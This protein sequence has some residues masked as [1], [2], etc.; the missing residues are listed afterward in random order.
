MFFF[1]QIF[2]T[3]LPYDYNVV[4]RRKFTNEKKK[5]FGFLFYFVKLIFMR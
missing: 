2:Y 1:Q 5:K 4:G 3:D